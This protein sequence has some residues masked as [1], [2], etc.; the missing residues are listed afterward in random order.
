MEC[1]YLLYSGL[2]GKFGYDSHASYIPSFWIHELQPGWSEYRGVVLLNMAEPPG[3]VEQ[4]FS[5]KLHFFM[6]N[7]VV[8]LPL[9]SFSVAEVKEGSLFLCTI[10]AKIC[11]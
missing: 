6:K 4:F 9:F 5:I 11:I 7:Y 3:K 1:I 2:R 8:T 10:S